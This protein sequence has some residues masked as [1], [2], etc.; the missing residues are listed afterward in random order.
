MCGE[1]QGEVQESSGVGAV[2]QVL[3]DML[4]KV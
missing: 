3:W 2:F 1:M 4:R